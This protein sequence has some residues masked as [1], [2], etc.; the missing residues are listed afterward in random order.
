MIQVIAAAYLHDVLEDTGVT[1]GRTGTEGVW[2]PGNIVCD[3]R[4]VRTSPYLAEQE[5]QRL[6]I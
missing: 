1:P 4:E 6:P 2:K 5:G 3:G